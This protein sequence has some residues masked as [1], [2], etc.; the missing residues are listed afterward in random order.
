MSLREVTNDHFICLGIYRTSELKT[1]QHKKINRREELLATPEPKANLLYLVVKRIEGIK[2]LDKAVVE[3]EAEDLG[4]QHRV[5]HR[6]SSHSGG[7]DGLR[8]RAGIGI[9]PH[10]QLPLH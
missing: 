2:Y 7:D 3:E 5:H 10:A 8:P 4:R 6:S 1:K 9:E